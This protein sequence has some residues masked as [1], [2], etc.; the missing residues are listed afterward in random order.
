MTDR[1]TAQRGVRGFPGDR[2]TSESVTEGHPDKVCDQLSDAV[3]DA[4]LAQDRNS[5]VACEAAVSSDFVLIFGEI[6]TQ[7][8]IDFDAIARGVLRRIGY[9]DPAIGFDAES[10][11]VVVRV[12]QQS[13]D[14]AEGL[15]R[16][17]RTG[18]SDDPY[19]LQGAGDQGMMIGFACDET[20]TLMPTPLWLADGLTRR[21]TQV[22]KNGELPWL[23]PDGKAQVTVEYAEGRPHR[24]STVVVSTQHTAAVS[25]SQIEHAMRDEVIAPTIPPELLDGETQY[26]INPAGN[27]IVGG[28]AADAG[29]TGRKIIVDT[30]GGI[31]RHGGG[32]FSGKDPS[33][34]DRSGAY[35]ARWVA[36]NIVAA[37]LA[38]RAEVQLSY[39]IG[40]PEP[41]SLTLL[42]FGTAQIAEAELERL[43]RGH[44]DLR[45][46]AIIEQLDLLRPIYEP[47]AAYGHFGR[48]DLE[49]PWEATGEVETLQAEAILATQM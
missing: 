21:L 12:K 18:D 9:T 24:V 15:R 26:F 1:Q 40:R 6:T 20:E 11:E 13:P 22:R 10:C 16:A 31:A 34:V 17:A 43:V 39:A 25:H 49:L 29:L 27:F 33:K 37:E 47:T 42:T 2:W 28:P 46:L 30:Y 48:A 36:K 23:R 38:E 45:P 3:L 19:D 7:A 4:C 44:F 5:R 41:T 32:A 8:E 14:I 35:A